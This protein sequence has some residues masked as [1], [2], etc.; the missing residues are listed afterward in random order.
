VL[1]YQS[2]LISPVIHQQW[3]EFSVSQSSV[4]R[5]AVT[6]YNI[7]FGSYFWC[8]WV[9]CVQDITASSVWLFL[10]KQNVHK[11]YSGEMVCSVASQGTKVQQKTLLKFHAE[12]HWITK[13]II[14]YLVKSPNYESPYYA[15]FSSF[16]LL[17]PFRLKYS[18]QHL[19]SKHSPTDG[20]LPQRRGERR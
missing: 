11:K 6:W 9:T 18:L 8:E 12:V 20:S 16:L 10:V 17:P 15:V 4:S 19:V 2:S 13:V 3:T 7:C 1:P 5:Y 14:Q